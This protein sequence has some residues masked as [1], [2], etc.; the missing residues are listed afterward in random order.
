[1][2]KQPFYSK[3]LEKLEELEVVFSCE[4]LKLLAPKRGNLT[5]FLCLSLLQNVQ[6]CER[7]VDV[8]GIAHWL[9]S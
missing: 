7:F 6:T 1:V 8:V 9:K 2:K 4:P 5:G 3:L